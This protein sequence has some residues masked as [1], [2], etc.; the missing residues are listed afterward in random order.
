MTINP[1]DVLGIFDNGCGCCTPEH[2]D[3]LLTDKT[4]VQLSPDETADVQ[5]AIERPSTVDESDS[6]STPGSHKEN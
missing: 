2:Y 6:Q 3:I 5:A 4:W 1:D